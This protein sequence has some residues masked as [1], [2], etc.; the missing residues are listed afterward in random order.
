[1]NQLAGAE[2]AGDATGADVETQRANVAGGY[3][4]RLGLFAAV[5][6]GFGLYCMYDGAITYPAQRE[7]ALVYQELASEE[8]NRLD[9][10]DAIA[11]K[12][13]WPTENPGDPK[14][15]ADFK[16]Q[17]FMA[18]ITGPP[19]FLCLLFLLHTRG[20][21]IEADDQ[22]LRTSWGAHCRFDEIVTLNK[23]LWKNK[24]IAKVYYKQDLIEGK[25]VLDDCKYDRYVTE[26]MLQL[27][28]SKINVEQI[29]GGPP[30]PTGEEATGEEAVDN[31]TMDDNPA[32][33]DG[34][35]ESEEQKTSQDES[36]A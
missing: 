7:R 24:G 17:F 5:G 18:A 13:G 33:A 32:D 6:I 36:E 11:E 12:N 35:M 34:Q 22:G 23:K 20:R 21:W 2:G 27:V 26:W 3:L 15:E 16:M 14:T 9:E 25:I 29:V 30:Q 31:E 4:A 28:E 19:G 10:W 1:M 8:N